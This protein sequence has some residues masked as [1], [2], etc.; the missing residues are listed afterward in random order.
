VTDETASVEKHDVVAVNSP[1]SKKARTVLYE[2]RKKVH[3]KR[4][5]GF[6]R[7]LKW[8]IMF[9]TLGIYYITPWL[10]WDRG[11][12]APDQAVL[13]DIAHRRFYFFFI[14][15]WPQEF[16][17]VA[18]LLIMGG[19]GLF[20]I[21][22]VVGRAWC[23]YT[24]WQ[25]VWTD[26]FLVV[27]RWVE[28]DRNARI[29][30]DAA[31]WTAGKIG[32]RVIKNAIWLVIGLLTGGAWIFYFADAPTLLKSFLTGQAP[33][34]AYITVGVLTFTTFI[35][36]GYMREQVCIYMCPWP[37]I[38]SA[39]LD[40]QSLVV[41]YNGWRGE[42]RSAHRKKMEA[43]GRKVG[44][45][46]DCNACVAVCPTGVDIRDG[47]QLGCITCALCIDA[48]NDVMAK[49]GKPKG[50]IS[51][52]NTVT[53]KAQAAGEKEFLHPLN[54][55]FRPRTLIYFS[56][57]A[58]AGLGMLLSVVTRDRLDINIVPD[59]NPL[60]VKLSDGSVRNGYTVKILNMQQEPRNF[61][62]TIDG[63]PGASMQV[64]ESEAA[65]GLT[66][67]IPV[68]ADKLKSVKVYIAVP[69]NELKSENTDFTFRLTVDGNDETSETPAIFHAPKKK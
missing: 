64:S 68:D 44:D 55:L 30:L 59:R 45:C 17:Y 8:I 29:K 52:S 25:T 15:I 3:P 53:Y 31:P 48:C 23:G 63:L 27:E 6:F 61:H 28:G 57:W 34:V 10:R 69:E 56:L 58:L 16:Y 66:A 19:V 37:R 24:C 49:I 7:Q 38:Q 62:V 14:E 20:L 54:I 9:V 67:D 11:E 18:G 5:S 1:K 43:Q 50:L 32:K 47:Q 22:S 2:A 21:T 40:E 51:Y 4:V 39:M 42:P 33:A 13:V 60:F 46:V 41:T 12:H 65:A 35:F 26:L 36:A